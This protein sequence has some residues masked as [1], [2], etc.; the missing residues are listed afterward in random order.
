MAMTSSDSDSDVVSAFDGRESPHHRQWKFPRLA[1]FAS[2]SQL[3]TCSP[4]TLDEW[5]KDE[6]EAVN[7]V[8][9]DLVTVDEPLP[10]PRPSPG[11]HNGSSPCASRAYNGFTRKQEPWPNPLPTSSAW[12]PL[13]FVQ[14]TRFAWGGCPEHRNRSLQPR[15]AQDQPWAGSVR[16]FCSGVHDVSE[17]GHRKCLVSFPFPQS[18]FHR[19]P[20]RVRQEAGS[21]ENSLLRGSA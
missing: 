15:V 4:Q 1:A 13:F 9:R 6:T 12:R 5:W 17:S 18:H 14:Q 7:G 3:S 19:L 8:V 11:T 20:I 16:L 10:A 2:E 21:V